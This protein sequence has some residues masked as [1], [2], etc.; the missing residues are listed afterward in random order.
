MFFIF[1]PWG[2]GILTPWQGMEPTL[3]ALEVEV[4][5]TEVLSLFLNCEIT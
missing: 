4:L 1:W 5:N 3:P 2:S